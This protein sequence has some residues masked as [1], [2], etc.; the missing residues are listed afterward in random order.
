VEGAQVLVVGVGEGAVGEVGL[1]A[2]HLLAERLGDVGPG[3]QLVDQ[4][5]RRGVAP[6]L[7]V[8]D[9]RLGQRRRPVIGLVIGPVIGPGVRA[10]IAGILG[11]QQLLPV[12]AGGGDRGVQRAPTP[13]PRRRRRP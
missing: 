11:D 10:G 3:Q 2:V 7:V 8:G 4:G 5:Q 12:R 13:A 9:F 1:V 6:A